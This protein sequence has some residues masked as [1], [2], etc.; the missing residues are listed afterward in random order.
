MSVHITNL[1]MTQTLQI[2]QMLETVKNYGKTIQNRNVIT[3]KMQNIVRA[4][5]KNYKDNKS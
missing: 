4:G 2:K 3:I 1:L 5:V